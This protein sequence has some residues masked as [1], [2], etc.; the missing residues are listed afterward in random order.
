MINIEYFKLPIQYVEHK[1][2]SDD[3]ID[4][5]EFKQF[6]NIDISNTSYNDNS[7]NSLYKQILEPTNLFSHAT[8]NLW[9]NYFTTDVSF[10]IQTQQLIKN[11][12]KP[13]QNNKVNFEYIYD[14][15]KDVTTD[16]NFLEKYQYIDISF[17]KRFNNNEHVLQTVSILNLSSPLLSL[18][19][20]IILLI[21]P[22]FIFKL[23]GLNLNLTT[24]LYLLKQV[25]TRHPIGQVITNFSSSS[26]DKKIYLCFTLIFYLFQMFQNAKSCYKFYKNLEL[27]NNNL[28]ELNNYIEY[29]LETID[30]FEK[31][32][33]HYSKYEL[34][35]S[36][37]NYY[38]N[39]LF[40]YKKE[41]ERINYSNFG[42]K[43]TFSI[44]TSMKNFYLLNNNNEYS[45]FFEQEHL[46]DI[47][48]C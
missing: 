24:Y 18:L 6:K 3:I 23:Y 36:I 27:I 42:I 29:T 7:Y 39:I 26:I 32:T 8:S 4:D 35:S 2:I 15:Y 30:I 17:F 12:K 44:G 33:I 20:P 38:K 47:E 1:L 10:L 16:N 21:M 9:S 22:L 45:F 41:L 25:F 5:L 46:I 48:I 37:M 43:K 13:N 19:V 40:I 14:I 34:F 11:F 28:Y 31:Q